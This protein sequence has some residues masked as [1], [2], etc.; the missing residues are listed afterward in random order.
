MVE[1]WLQD[2]LSL[3][4]R[5]AHFITG[6]A[7][8]GASFYFNWLE[9]QLERRVG[10][11][12]IAGDLWAVHGGGFY[13]LQKFRVAPESLPPKLHWFK[14]EA[15]FTWLTGFV[16]LATIYYWGASAF[17][18]D[19]GLWPLSPLQAIGLSVLSLF[20]G[21]VVY[22][23]ACRSP[24]G[25][26]TASLALG[27][28][29]L[30]ASACVGYTQVFSG[31]AAFLHIGVFIGTI[32]AANVFLV[33]IP[34]QKKTV[35]ALVDGRDPDPALGAQA[36]Q[37]SLHNNYL[38]LPVLFMMISNHYPIVFGHAW[39]WLV[40]IGIVVAG[41][42]IRHF[43]N[44]YD[45][46]ALDWTGRAALPA[47]ALAIAA[48]VAVTASRVTPGAGED[49]SFAQVRTIIANRCVTCHAE[50]PTHESFEDAPSGVVFETAE[51]I[52]RYADKIVTQTVLT[53]T[54]PLGNLTG[55]TD[56]ERAL[57]GA[58]VAQGARID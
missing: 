11:D 22:D 2:W 37:R 50:A 33:I 10:D 52:A 38:T 49:V 5:W 35:A 23:L 14:Y 57:L 28:F 17:L 30:V 1:T 40:A 29:V 20:A 6:V 46:A 25:A 54:M 55:M 26:N 44:Q 9:N 32:M 43:F 4:L 34:N 24:L 7:W 42:L 41:G 56:E 45:A 15:Y 47:G 21:W 18:I 3:L 19:P 51:D 36:K 48:L 12:P 39:S 16:L 58:W 13:Y 53:D 8:I 31:R 27:V